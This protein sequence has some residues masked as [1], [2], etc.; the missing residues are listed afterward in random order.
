MDSPQRSRPP[1]K[2]PVPLPRFKITVR[3][4]VALSVMATRGWREV[5]GDYDWDI[6]WSARS[7]SCRTLSIK[8]PRWCRHAAGLSA[9]GV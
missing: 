2:A 8:G 7:L 4:C 5:S 1:G 6:F 3:S 9:Q